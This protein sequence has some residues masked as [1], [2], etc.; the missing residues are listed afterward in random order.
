MTG[1]VQRGRIY[2]LKVGDKNKGWEISD[3]N[4]SFDVTKSANN[5][6]KTNS[7]TVEI[8]NLSP[9]KRAYLEEDYTY[10][11]LKVGYREQ[12]LILLFSGQATEVTS[13]KSGQDIVTRI[14]I[15]S[16][17]T[18]INHK[19]ISKLV[20]AGRT[21]KDVIEELRKEIPSVSRAVYTGVN[22]NSQVVDGYPISTT[23]RKTLDDLAR[24]YKIDWQIDN[25]VL[26]TSDSG[27]SHSNKS[28]AI[29]ISP[30][31]GLIE[32]PYATTKEV[33]PEGAPK[34][35]KKGEK[36]VKS[37]KKGVQFKHLL[38][39]NLVAG[40]IVK[41]ESEQYDGFYKVNE[42]RSYGEW[43]GN[44]WYSDVSAERL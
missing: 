28:S 30:T 39:P 37:R 14:S 6:D 20:P 5:K 27:G 35:A 22:I 21:V 34:R 42:I 1:I 11:E 4:I 13:R 3:L 32:V 12:G 16:A 38:N 18:D 29:V 40:G 8:Y 17:Y 26:Y 2:S 31:T 41:I 43:L 33:T 23:A 7:A 36:V 9:D 19:T 25:G 10:V 24:A 44:D 15:G